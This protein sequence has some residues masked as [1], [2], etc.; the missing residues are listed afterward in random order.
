MAW[1]TFAEQMAYGARQLKK[2]RLDTGQNIILTTASTLKRTQ[3]RLSH[4][5]HIAKITTAGRHT[6]QFPLINQSNHLRPVVGV[7]SANNAARIKD[8]CVQSAGDAPAAL[9]FGKILAT[10]VIDLAVRVGGCVFVDQAVMAAIGG[11]GGGQD[12]AARVMLV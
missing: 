9:Q 1:R 12:K 7:A 5:T 8:H 6:G 2:A 4:F 10:C 3:M 11:K